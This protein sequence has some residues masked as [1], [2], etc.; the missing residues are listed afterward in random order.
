MAN[1]IIVDLSRCVMG[2]TPRSGETIL[3]PTDADVSRPRVF[4]VQA[5]IEKYRIT[6]KQ[7]KKKED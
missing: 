5:S 3:K 4:T 7:K 6:K 1:I 2:R